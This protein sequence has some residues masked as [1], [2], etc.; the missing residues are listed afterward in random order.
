MLKRI[1]QNLQE[2]KRC[3]GQF[4]C[5][6]IGSLC[7]RVQRRGT[8]E[9]AQRSNQFMIESRLS[10]M[11]MERKSSDQTACQRNTGHE[12]VGSGRSEHNG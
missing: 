10:D 6:G 9:M 1:F 12:T 11:T 3:L 7:Q 8:V 5:I 4:P 2:R